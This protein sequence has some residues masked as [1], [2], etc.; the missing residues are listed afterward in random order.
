MKKQE[1]ES[2]QKKA[3]SEKVDRTKYTTT[4][5]DNFYSTPFTVEGDDQYKSLLWKSMMK[6]AT[7]YFDQPSI[8]DEQ[9]MLKK[10][11]YRYDSLFSTAMRPTLQSRNDLVQWTCKAQNAWM[12][13]KGAP[14][15]LK[16]ECSSTRALL[17]T[18]GPDYTTIKKKL[19]YVKGLIPDDI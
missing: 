16:M 15:E 17:E 4:S 5:I 7:F 12:E 1:D 6:D 2:A 18:Y 9:S 11:Q 10:L 19:G 14:Q 13:E 8:E 3:Y